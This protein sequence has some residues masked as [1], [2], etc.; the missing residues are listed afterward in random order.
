MKIKISV[1]HSIFFLVIFSGNAQE[2]KS[3]ININAQF[4]NYLNE[5]F[6]PVNPGI[7]FL[8][9]NQFVGPFT[10]SAGINY[11]YTSWKKS[12]GVK[13]HFKRRYHEIFVP[14]IL[15]AKITNEIHTAFGIYP[16]WLFNGK[17]LYKGSSSTGNWNDNTHNTDYDESSKFAADLFFGL[18][19]FNFTKPNNKSHSLKFT[20]FLKCRLKE[21]WLNENRDNPT[22]F[23]VKINYMI[24]FN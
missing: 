12:I 18:E 6:S 19:L 4:S 22:S 5:Y 8:Y 20:P 16:G 10:I 15:K 13:S 24:S 2:A 21:N 1:L 17:E 3:S 11:S 23:G 9:E 14:V 7:E